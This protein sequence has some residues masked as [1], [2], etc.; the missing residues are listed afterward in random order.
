MSYEWAENKLKLERAVKIS[1]TK[2]ESDVK[3]IYV[4]LGGKLKNT[5]PKV[6]MGDS[7]GK[8]EIIPE[9]I[10]FEKEVSAIESKKKSN[11]K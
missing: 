4:S 11:S 1:E 8:A 10:T 3:I 6:S 9:G 2:Q 5:E 7:I